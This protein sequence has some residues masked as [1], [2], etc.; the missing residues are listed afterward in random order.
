MDR[1]II[2]ITN[3]ELDEVE[4]TDCYNYEDDECGYCVFDG[5]DCDIFDC[6]PEGSDGLFVY[7]DEWD[8]KLKA[9]EFSERTIT[10][11]EYHPYLPT[12]SQRNEL[13]DNPGFLPIG[14]WDVGDGWKHPVLEG[15]EQAHKQ[16]D[17]EE[18]DKKKADI[19]K[20]K[21]GQMMEDFNLALLAVSEVTRYGIEKYERPG[22]WKHAHKELVKYHDAAM[23]HYLK[24]HTEKYDD[25]SGY[26]HL[27]QVAW[28]VLALIQM[29][30]E[31]GK[32][33]PRD[34]RKITKAIEGLTQKEPEWFKG[35]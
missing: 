27:I 33:K 5:L 28:N 12:I 25:E 22:S 2:Y 17:G 3:Q 14:S 10:G 19:T 15:I 8:E 23:R 24:S 6:S 30:L 26:L 21:P 9:K 16:M 11:A 31:F 1:K 32:V 35:E 4:G 18:Q 7:E 34:V 13:V 20:A 29:Q